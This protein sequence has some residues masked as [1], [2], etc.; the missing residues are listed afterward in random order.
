MS[1]LNF[2]DCLKKYK[3]RKCDFLYKTFNLHENERTLQAIPQSRL[4]NKKA[5]RQGQDAAL[6]NGIQCLKN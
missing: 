2:F 6:Q 1:L 5:K 4:N 3:S